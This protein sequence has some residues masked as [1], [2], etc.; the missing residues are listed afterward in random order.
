MWK[1]AMSVKMAVIS[2]SAVFSLFHFMWKDI[3]YPADQGYSNEI[4]RNESQV[5]TEKQTIILELRAPSHT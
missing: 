1:P 5:Y 3:H 4:V 2:S